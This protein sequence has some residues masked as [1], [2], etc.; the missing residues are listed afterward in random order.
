[1][2]DVTLYNQ[3]AF[4]C[5]KAFYQKLLQKL[6]RKKIVVAKFNNF[7]LIKIMDELFLTLLCVQ[8][9]ILTFLEATS[10]GV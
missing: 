3:P 9:K 5:R 7:K 1:M 6:K 2:F 8:T 10:A 4:S